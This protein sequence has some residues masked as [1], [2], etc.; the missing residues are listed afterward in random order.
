MLLNPAIFFYRRFIFT[1]SVI[2]FRKDIF[3]L[4]IIQMGLIQIQLVVLHFLR[5]FESK[6]ALWKQTQDECTYLLLLYVL[7]CFTDFVP[8]PEL[9]NKLGIVY[10]TIMFTNIGTHLVSLIRFTLS[11]FLRSLKRCFVRRHLYWCFCCCKK[12]SKPMTPV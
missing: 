12:K 4:I 7:L 9:R 1:C 10:I 11:S 6:A 3:A 2:I 5:V 8:D